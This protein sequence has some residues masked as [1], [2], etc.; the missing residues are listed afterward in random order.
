MGR[1]GEE[2]G[3]GGA[4]GQTGAAVQVKEEARMLI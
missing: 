3:G 2:R 1:G 4:Q